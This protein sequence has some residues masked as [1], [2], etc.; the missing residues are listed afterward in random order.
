MNDRRLFL[1]SLGLAMLAPLVGG[2]ALAAPLE[3]AAAV[4]AP[5]E[6]RA[7]ALAGG[8]YLVDAGSSPRPTWA[9]S[10]SMRFDTATP[11]R[12]AFAGIF[13]VCVIG[14]GPA[15]ITLA[16]RLAARG[17]EVALMEAGDIYWSE[18]SQASTS[19]RSPGRPTTA[20]TWR[21]CAISAA[22]PG[23]GTAPAR[24]SS[25]RASGRTR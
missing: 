9:R 25:P 1:Q 21:G 13:D 20:S 15:G 16:R 6:V 22:P 19:A 14:S 5:T 17:L 11:E 10:A 18:E 2:A 24:T 3:A 12:E 4:T 7:T 23:T 8:M